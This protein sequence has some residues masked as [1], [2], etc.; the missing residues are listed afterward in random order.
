MRPH[1]KSAS[2]VLTKWDFPYG[3]SP[4]SENIPKEMDKS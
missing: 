1:R 2:T 4:V 3:E